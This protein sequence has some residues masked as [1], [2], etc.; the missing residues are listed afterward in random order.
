MSLPP[1][2]CVRH[3]LWY[4]KPE[5]GTRVEQAQADL[6]L[7]LQE[8]VAR[9][10][11][12]EATVVAVAPAPMAAHELGWSG[13]E[14]RR[15]RVALDS[16]DSLTLITK[17]MPLK[18]RRVLVL[19]SEQ[20]HA[21]VPFTHTLDLTTDAPALACMQ[22]V[23]GDPGPLPPDLDARVARALAAIHYRNLGQGDRLPW[24]PRA[25]HAYFADFLIPEVWRAHWD[26]AL[27][28]PP[29]A[30][31]FAAYTPRLEAA[32][33][34]FIAAMDMLWDEGTS[35]TVTHGDMHP[36]DGS[37]VITRRGTPYLIDWGWTYYGSFYLDLP[38]YFTPAS[39]HH[40]RAALADLGPAIP[41][42]AFMARFHAAARYVGFKYLCAG[43]WQWPPG[44]TRQT[45]RM[46]LN[47]LRRALDGAPPDSGFTLAGATWD[48]LLAAHMQFTGQPD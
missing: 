8:T 34:H 1:F 33:A 19:L 43:I 9:Y 32:A 13:A 26:T 41:E 3:T 47:M 12:P 2:L 10:V 15:Y 35:L 24:L 4:H 29:F 5:R 31:E 23:G 44:P 30:A 45:G 27:A 17:T 16:G 38:N 20:G 11:A 21:N 7:L 39:V 48:G 18:E 14:V 28:N 6:R 36:A 37:H 40:Y 25:D 22:D 42:A 46:L